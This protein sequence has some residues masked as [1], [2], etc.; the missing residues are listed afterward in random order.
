MKK[1]VFITILF[2]LTIA[3]SGQTLKKGALVVVDSYE[4]TLKPD[5]TLNQFIDFYLNKYIPEFEKN[6]PGTK[7]YLLYGDRGEHKNQIGVAM[8]CESVEIRD[9]YWPKEDGES[10]ELAKAAEAKMAPINEEAGK[11]MLDAKRKYTDWIVK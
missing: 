7:V 1:L 3:V 11:Y 5:V 10:S 4:L 2:L 8:I 6:Y 9:K